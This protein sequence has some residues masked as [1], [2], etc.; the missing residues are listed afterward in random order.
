MKNHLCVL[1][2]SILFINISACTSSIDSQTSAIKQHCTKKEKCKKYKK[3]NP[4]YNCQKCSLCKVLKKDC[5]EWTSHKCWKE[6]CKQWLWEKQCKKVKQCSSP[7]CSKQS[8]V[9]PYFIDSGID[10]LEV[11]EDLE[12][13]DILGYTDSSLDTEVLADLTEFD[14]VDSETTSDTVNVDS[15]SDSKPPVFHR[16]PPETHTALAGG[17]SLSGESNFSYLGII[18][19]GFVFL[20][21]KFFGLIF[22]SFILL[23]SSTSFG[24]EVSTQNLKP[25]FQSKDILVSQSPLFS[26]STL[27]ILYQ[28]EN[29]PLR[30]I[31]KPSNLT[32]EKII[33]QRHTLHFLG[34]LTLNERLQLGIDVPFVLGQL[35]GEKV[36]LLNLAHLEGGLADIRL[37]GKVKIFEYKTFGLGVVIDWTLPTSNVE[38]VDEDY[39]SL[40][41]LLLASFNLDRISVLGN[42]GPVIR[43]S[44]K[45]SEPGLQKHDFGNQLFA[46]LGSKILL[47]KNDK[48]SLDLL[49]D[50][51][52]HSPLDNILAEEVA[53]ELLSGVSV[54]F[55]D[56][57]IS[58]ANG[59]GLTKGVG[60]PFPRLLL[61]FSWEPE[62]KKCRPYILEKETRI[63]I[64][65]EVEKVIKEPYPVPIPVFISIPSVYF[66]TAKAEL[67]QETKEVLVE[68]ADFLI[69]NP[70]VTIR[71][72]GNADSRGKSH[73][74]QKLS[75]MR[76]QVVVDYFRSIGVVNKIEEVSFGEDA[77]LTKEQDK[78]SLQ[79]NRR[80]DIH[81]ID[82]ENLL[83][84]K[85]PK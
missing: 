10:D 67:P 66:D 1:L 23:F 13:L 5:P 37:I 18:L 73:Y 74:N 56:F 38:L 9:P 47:L 4:D 3:S 2:C 68:I 82:Q 43:K 77:P 60:N 71:I 84:P 49:V 65:K 12:S 75:S 62:T 42:I 76:V 17:C 19:I 26:K 16:D 69:N 58:L 78:S 30:L 48:L 21:K 63:E 79:K 8:C 51:Q 29:R 22:S 57:Q 35:E 36:D 54:K 28:F 64:T 83:F 81:I 59:I 41:P 25:V 39:G 53:L 55:S 45:L 31:D 70:E 40:T 11:D 15:S 24:Q 72:S 7:K 20:R 50:S 52:I 34:L 46:S 14:S 27:S 85:E 32:L 44:T 6:Y 33:R 80:V 61:S